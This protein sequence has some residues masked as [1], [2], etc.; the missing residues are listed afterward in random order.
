[1]TDTIHF[2]RKKK[3]R[4]QFIFFSFAQDVFIVIHT[5]E[6]KN[7]LTHVLYSII[8]NYR[9]KAHSLVETIYIY[10]LIC[11]YNLHL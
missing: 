3:N 5:Y 1:M 7:I 11:L 4:E 8:S 2:R 6:I 10:H 9:A